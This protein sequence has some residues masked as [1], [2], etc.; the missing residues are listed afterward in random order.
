MKKANVKLN[1]QSSVSAKK[2][3]SK[4]KDQIFKLKIES[5]SMDSITDAVEKVIAQLHEHPVPNR[6]FIPDSSSE[7]DALKSIMGSD[8]EQFSRSVRKLKTRLFHIEKWDEFEPTYI[9][10][11]IDKS[12]DK[13][14][15]YK[16]TFQKDPEIRMVV[17]VVEKGLATNSTS[18]HHSHIIELSKKPSAFKKHLSAAFNLIGIALLVELAII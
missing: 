4:N 9:F 6:K 16:V 11:A 1:G 7:H 13:I 14:E 3:K 12:R 2:S 8:A 17:D 5:A 15:E 18:S 10:R